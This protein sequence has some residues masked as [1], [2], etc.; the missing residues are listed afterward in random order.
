MVR[1][2]DALFHGEGLSAT[3]VFILVAVTVEPQDLNNRH[4]QHTK[5][6]VR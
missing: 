3:R 1:V 4:A 5:S 2:Y 6:E